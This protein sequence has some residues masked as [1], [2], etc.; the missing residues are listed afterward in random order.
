LNTH[1]FLAPKVYALVSSVAINEG[2]SG[3]SQIQLAGSP[4]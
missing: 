1:I 4:W 2:E 3:L